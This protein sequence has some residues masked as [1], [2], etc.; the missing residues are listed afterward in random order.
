MKEALRDLTRRMRMAIAKV[1][2]SGV[3]DSPGLQS[4]QLRLMADEAKGGLTH[5]QHYGF[6]SNPHP[7]AEG[8][9]FFIGGNR[10]H[11][12]ALNLDDRRYRP[13]NIKAGE[14]ILYTDE[15]QLAGGHRIHFKR[16][17]EIDIFAG[18]KVTIQVGDTTRL[19]LT[20]AGVKLITP[21]FQ[22]DQS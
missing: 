5:L 16:G 17:Q 2:L 4:V 1:V 3:D 9:A 21:D 19:E 11:G 18:K 6:S 22:A 14:V 10:D 12:V 7:G 13:R 20:P 8:V 15:D